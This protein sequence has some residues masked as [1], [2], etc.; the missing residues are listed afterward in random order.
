METFTTPSR[1]IWCQSSTLAAMTLPVQ[2]AHDALFFHGLPWPPVSFEP[3][4]SPKKGS[5]KAP[6]GGKPLQHNGWCPDPGGELRRLA[7]RLRGR[8]KTILAGFT[9]GGGRSRERITISGKTVRKV[10]PTE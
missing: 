5:S 6:P 7:G 1:P 2:G 4:E 8:P 10:R 3:E 9:S